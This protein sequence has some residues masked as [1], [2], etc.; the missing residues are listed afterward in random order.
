M[1]VKKWYALV[2]VKHTS[3]IKPDAYDYILQKSDVLECIV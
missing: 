2:Y 3:L 1:F